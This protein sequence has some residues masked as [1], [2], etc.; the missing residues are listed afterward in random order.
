[1]DFILLGAYI[2]EYGLSLFPTR[3]KKSDLL[4][5]VNLYLQI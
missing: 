2:K 3:L 5:L 1:M 4:S